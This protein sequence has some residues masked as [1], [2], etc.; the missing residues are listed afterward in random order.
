MNPP[1]EGKLHLEVLNKVLKEPIIDELVDLSPANQMFSG[2]RLIKDHQYISSHQELIQH[3]QD[4][5][6]IKPEE[7]SDIFGAAF[8]GPLMLIHY[9]KNKEGKNYKDFNIIKHS[10][11]SI[12]D[13]TVFAVYKGKYPNLWDEIFKNNNNNKQH[14]K[15]FLTCP[16]VHGHQGHSDWAEITSSNYEVALNSKQR[17]GWHLE[18]DTEEERKNCYDVWHL[19]FHKFLHSL[20]KA[21]NFN[22]YQWL[23]LLDYTH[24]WTDEQLYKYFDLTPE[25]VNIIETEINSGK[26]CS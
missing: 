5:D 18:F 25:E 23:P 21:D 22:M 12:A 13:K 7:A 8:A 11:R 26:D 15:W 1:Y 14:K 19:P 10:L 6:L 17:F 9:D 3:I 4:V 24:P 20:I 2:I 16:E